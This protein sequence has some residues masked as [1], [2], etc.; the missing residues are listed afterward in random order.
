MPHVSTRSKTEGNW[1]CNAQ[2]L[3]AVI[4]ELLGHLPA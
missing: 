2:W 4:A 1:Q 3:D